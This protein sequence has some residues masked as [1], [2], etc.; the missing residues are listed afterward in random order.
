[1]ERRKASG[2]NCGGPCGSAMAPGRL[3]IEHALDF[4]QVRRRGGRQIRHL[5]YQP[6]LPGLEIGLLDAD[7]K[8]SLSPFFTHGV[9]KKSQETPR[10]ELQTAEARM[11]DYIQRQGGRL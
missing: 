7:R 8:T 2:M 5:F 6:L 9:K 10:R 1:M 3:L 4:A 11:K